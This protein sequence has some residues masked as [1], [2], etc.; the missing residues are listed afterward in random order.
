VDYYLSAS[1]TDAT[2]SIR[3]INV[4][5]QRGH[6]YPRIPL[7]QCDNGNARRLNLPSRLR[8]WTPLHCTTK[9]A[10][11]STSYLSLQR[12]SVHF[13]QRRLCQVDELSNVNCVPN[14]DWD[15]GGRT[16]DV[17]PRK[18]CGYVS[19]GGKRED[20][21]NLDIANPAWPDCWTNCG[22]LFI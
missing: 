9:R 22:G 3:I 13:I 14:P 10:L 7:W 15:C 8:L 1:N 12:C 16:I 5:P 21:G 4:R 6:G 19:A 2:H 17:G 20:H 11:R 18:Y